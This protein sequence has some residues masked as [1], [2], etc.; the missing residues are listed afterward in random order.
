LNKTKGVLLDLTGKATLQVRQHCAHVIR[1]AFKH[2]AH[3]SKTA[4]TARAFVFQKVGTE[5]IPAHNLTAT[6][7]FKALRSRFASFQ[8][9]HD[10]F[11]IHTVLNNNGYCVDRDDLIFAA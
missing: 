11:Q 7:R 9:R 4:L 2:K 8:L 10:K 5:G 6:R 3:A 1:V